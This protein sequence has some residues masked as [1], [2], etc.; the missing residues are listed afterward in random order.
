MI[1]PEQIQ[2]FNDNGYLIVRD[3]LSLQEAG[4]LQPWAQQVHDYVPDETSNIMPYE[5]LTS[6]ESLII[7][8]A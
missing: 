7:A 3:F 8:H 1:S 5:V 6:S 2:F 4:S